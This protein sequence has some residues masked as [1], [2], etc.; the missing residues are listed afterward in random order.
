MTGNLGNY[1]DSG[2]IDLGEKKSTE[3]I[4]K[5]KPTI[6]Q[7]FLMGGFECS[8]HLNPHRRRVDV[9]ASTRHD[10]FAETDYQMLM[11]FGMKTAR[12]GVRWHLI[13]HKPFKYDFSSVLNQIRAAR[14]TGI[15]IIWDLFHYGYPADLDIYDAEFIERFTK[16]TEE[17]TVFLLNEDERTP[18]F[19]PVNEISFFAWIAAEVAMFYPYQRHRA[20]ELKRQLVR[21]TISAIDTIRKISP[22]AR[23]VQADPAIE[24]T[25]TSKKNNF[26]NDAGNFRESQFQAF[27]MLTGKSEPELGGA[28]KYLDIVGINFYSQNQ[29][30]HPSGK[31]VLLGHKDY[32]P[33]SEI[34][35]EY[36]ER[37]KRPLLIAE[38]GIEDDLRP[39]WFRYICEQTKIAESRGVPVE[40]ICLYPILNHPGWDDD[41]H[42]YNGLWDYADE[43]GNREIYQ[44]LA[45]EIEKLVG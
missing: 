34:L 42:C 11:D 9:I 26:I 20:D 13:E 30:R 45:D 3:I 31:R 38:T 22:N 39:S 37:Y 12:D 6:F 7:S 23:F 18:V 43:T 25:T 19:C 17:F 5:N 21:A 16:F 24:V 28:A 1:L 41:R 10:E 44:P 40:G 33:F 2:N 27:D 36:Y 8:T 35:F 4:L 15:Q 29:W 32:R 14:K